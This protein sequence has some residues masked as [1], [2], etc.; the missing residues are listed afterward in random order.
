VVKGVFEVFRGETL[1]DQALVVHA[2]NNWHDHILWGYCGFFEKLGHAAQERG[3]ATLLV[4]SDRI[5]AP[6]PLVGPQKR[7]MVGPRKFR[8]P[9]IFH[10]YPSYIEG[11]WYLDPQGYFWNSTMMDKPFDPALVDFDEA[12]K[13]FGHVSSWRIRNNVSQR[14]QPP[15]S[16]LPCAEVAVFTQDIELYPDNVHYLTTRQII[17]SAAGAVQGLCY[18]KPHPLMTGE[19]RSW[20]SKLCGRLPNTSLVD[21]SVHDIIRASNVIVSQNSAVGFEA[22]MHRKPAITCAKTDYA[23]ASLVS[24]TVDELRTNIRCAT[25]RFAEFPYERYF[26]WFL[27]MNML[28]PQAEDFTARA[29]RI[30][31]GA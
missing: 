6:S 31:Y 17:R 20:L 27:G 21:A 2:N 19:Q 14:Q 10:A 13:F 25:S 23:I 5:G 15:T 7:I 28:Q 9:N 3:I 12:A 29:M 30:L 22:L 16:S 26:Y 18:V 8:G 24:H 1:P 11:F 4:R